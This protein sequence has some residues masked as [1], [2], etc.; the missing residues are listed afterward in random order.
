MYTIIYIYI[1]IYIGSL[2]WIINVYYKNHIKY[3]KT[4]V[5]MQSNKSNL[6]NDNLETETIILFVSR[7]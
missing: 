6:F 4:L 5:A 1:Y 7:S 2:E 3:F